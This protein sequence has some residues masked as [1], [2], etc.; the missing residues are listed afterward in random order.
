M[1]ERVDFERTD[2]PPSLLAK[3]AAGVAAFV[4]AVPLVMMLIYPQTRQPRVRTQ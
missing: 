3:L 4:I 1:T 2:A